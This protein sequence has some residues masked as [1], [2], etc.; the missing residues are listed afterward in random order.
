MV[1][2]RGLEPPQNTSGRFASVRD[3]D[4][5]TTGYAPFL[6]LPQRT[7]SPLMRKYSVRNC[8]E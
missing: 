3:N 8:Q 5:K 7:V 6:K 2:E 4:Y 1:R